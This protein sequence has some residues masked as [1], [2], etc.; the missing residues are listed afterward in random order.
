MSASTKA[1][2]P[3]KA[4]RVTQEF[5]DERVAR[6]AA[7]PKAKWI[8]FCETLMT[9]GFRVELYEAR[10]TVSK[11]VTISKM[12]KSFKVRFSN[13]KPIKHRQMKGDCDFF[14]GVSHSLVT[15]TNDALKAVHE[16]FS[17]ESRQ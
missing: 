6:A 17:K 9:Q 4:M 13:H 1:G 10:E 8:I 5:L 16:Y 2:V 7:W 15:T 3:G 11:Y 14:V 12:G